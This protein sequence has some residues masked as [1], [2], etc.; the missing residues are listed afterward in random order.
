LSFFLLSLE[1]FQKPGANQGATWRLMEDEVPDREFCPWQDPSL[2]VGC[3]LNAVSTLTSS[4]CYGLLTDSQPIQPFF[5]I[6]TT[7]NDDEVT[8]EPVIT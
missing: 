1:E 8:N 6:R 2:A 5:Q 4:C 3:S 7:D